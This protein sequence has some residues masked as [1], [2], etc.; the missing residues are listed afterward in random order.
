MH[1]KGDDAHHQTG[2]HHLCLRCLSWCRDLNML[3]LL[4]LLHS[5]CCSLP[6]APHLTRAVTQQSC[7]PQASRQ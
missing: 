2:L 4:L 5:C 6:A 3:L 7:C 1:G